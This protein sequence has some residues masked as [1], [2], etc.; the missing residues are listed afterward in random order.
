MND[1]LVKKF[2]AKQDL[3]ELS[4]EVQEDR[5]FEPVVRAPL[6]KEL[7]DDFDFAQVNLRATLE[8]GQTLLA[9]LICVARDSMH[10]RSFEVAATLLKTLGDLSSQLLDLHKKIPAKEIKED[11]YLLAT[12]KDLDD[13]LER[14]KK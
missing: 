8:V 2:L 11:T 1:D 10:P 12:P 13:I 4:T 9:D 6:G 5:T 14:I 3:Q 7:Q